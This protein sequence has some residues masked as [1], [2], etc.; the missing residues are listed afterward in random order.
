MKFYNKFKNT[1]FM[2]SRLRVRS[3]FSSPWRLARSVLL[4]RAA[5]SSSSFF[6]SP[7]YESI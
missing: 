4:I 1:F 3:C 5:S 6:S 2:I 7:A